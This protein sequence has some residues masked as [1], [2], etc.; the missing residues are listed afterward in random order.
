MDSI[1]SNDNK[2]IINLSQVLYIHK[3][4]STVIVFNFNEVGYGNGSYK[5]N[6][7]VRFESEKERDEAFDK[8][9]V[10]FDVFKL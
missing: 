8:L 4:E 2:T 1:L 10:Q 9:C 7:S 6:K 3:S 5:Q